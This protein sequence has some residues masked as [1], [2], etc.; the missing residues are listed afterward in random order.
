MP[1][2]RSYEF[3]SP[4]TSFGAAFAPPV[5]ARLPARASLRLPW[6][7]LVWLLAQ[8]LALLDIASSGCLAA[9]FGEPLDWPVPSTWVSQELGV[10][11]IRCTS[12]AGVPTRGSGHLLLGAPTSSRTHLLARATAPESQPVFLDSHCLSV[13]LV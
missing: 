7:R 1:V 4:L 3:R 13:L 9:C 10:Y 2:R 8:P 11:P 12:G 6:H 5:R